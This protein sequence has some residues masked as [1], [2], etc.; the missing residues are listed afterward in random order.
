MASPTLYITTCKF[1]L[2]I[3]LDK[4]ANIKDFTNLPRIL[5]LACVNHNAHTHKSEHTSNTVRNTRLLTPTHTQM[6]TILRSA[7]GLPKRLFG[8][9]SWRTNHRAWAST[10]LS[11]SERKAALMQ[12]ASSA[13]PFPWT[14]VRF[15]S[16][17]CKYCIC[18]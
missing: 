5:L 17:G 18:T 1:F 6:K 13:S 8:F 12:L 4:N 7:V 15:L 10:S 11:D 14:E 3:F 16:E 9:S 2:N